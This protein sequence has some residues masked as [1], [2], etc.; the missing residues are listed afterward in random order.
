MREF[1][2]T[3]SALVAEAI[4]IQNR[5]ITLEMFLN[6]ILRLNRY[7]FVREQ[8]DSSWHIPMQS[9][10][11]LGRII[12]ARP[13]FVQMFFDEIFFYRDQDLGPYNEQVQLVL[14]NRN[15]MAQIQYLA[16]IF[17]RSGVSPNLSNAQGQTLYQRAYLLNRADIVRLLES[18]GAHR[19]RIEQPIAFPET[20]VP[21]SVAVQTTL[22]VVPPCTLVAVS[23][24]RGQIVRQR[25]RDVAHM[26]L[27]PFNGFQSRGVHPRD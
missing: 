13:A 24:T 15:L 22:A 11:L 6:H 16:H 4:A 10:T 7:I 8:L 9:Q 1:P 26:L 20:R 14:N 27:M 5:P 3:T 23:P 21:P 25:M 19:T 12:N 18:F 17:F 2:I